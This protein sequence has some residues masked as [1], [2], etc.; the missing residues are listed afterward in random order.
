MGLRDYQTTGL[1]DYG[2]RDYET[3]ELRNH[4]LLT[5]AP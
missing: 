1:R 3:T 2:L 5:T 4:G